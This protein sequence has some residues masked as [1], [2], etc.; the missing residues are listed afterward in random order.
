MC[1]HT[2]SKR[3]IKLFFLTRFILN[4]FKIETLGSVSRKK[5]KQ[6]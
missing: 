2:K 4:D 6:L 5:I 1:K 3:R